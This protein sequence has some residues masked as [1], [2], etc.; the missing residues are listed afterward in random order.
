MILLFNKKEKQKVYCQTC[1]EDLT[2]QGGYISNEGGIYCQGG[3][4]RNFD[5]GGIAMT[6]SNHNLSFDYADSKEVQRWIEEGKL[7]HFSQLEKTVSK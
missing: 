4:L 7:I 2:K 5:C 6:K 3:F 1:G